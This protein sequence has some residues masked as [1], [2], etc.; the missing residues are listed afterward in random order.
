MTET[1]YILVD[2]HRKLPEG[3]NVRTL[4]SIDKYFHLKSDGTVKIPANLM[5]SIEEITIDNFQRIFKMAGGTIETKTK[6]KS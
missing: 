1:A 2:R 6:N 5:A 3:K 4:F